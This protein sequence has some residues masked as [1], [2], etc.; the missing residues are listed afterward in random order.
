LYTSETD[1]DVSIQQL[2]GNVIN[3]IWVSEDEHDL[4]LS[5]ENGRS[6]IASTEGDCC[7]E[8]WWADIV[9]VNQIIGSKV[10]EAGTMPL[11]EDYNLEDGRTRDSYDEAYGFK[12][13]TER[14]QCDLIFRNSS[15]GY[16]GGWANCKWEDNPN[17]DRFRQIVENNWSA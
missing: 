14:G 10:I 15:N 8:S 17:L 5:L 12:I 7:S 2:E 6:F 16:Y 9:G 3:S 13:T 11:P 1:L 4:I